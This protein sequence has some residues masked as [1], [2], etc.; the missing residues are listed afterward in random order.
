MSNHAHGLWGYTGTTARGRELTIQATGVGGPSAALVLADLAA[1]GV[2]RA[3]RV[4]TCVA[5]DDLAL[6]TIVN[7]DRALAFD[8][9]S[10]ALGA[11]PRPCPTRGLRQSC[12]ARPGGAPRHGRAAAT[13]RMTS[14]TTPTT[15]ARRRDW[16]D[17]GAIAA[18]MAAAPCSRPGRRL[19]VATAG[20]L[21]VTELAGADERIGDDELAERALERGAVLD[22]RRALVGPTRPDLRSA[23]R[24]TSAISSSRSSTSSRRPDRMRSRRSSRSTSDA[25]GMFIALIAERWAASA[26]SPAPNVVERTELKSGF[27]SSAWA[28]SPS[29]SSPA[30]E[31]RS[32]SSCRPDPSRPLRSLRSP[33]ASSPAVMAWG[34]RVPPVAA[35]WVK[36]GACVPI[37]FRVD[38][39]CRNANP[40]SRAFSSASVRQLLY[41]CAVGVGKRRFGV[42]QRGA[43]K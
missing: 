27:S 41:G 21:V 12:G 4:G 15:A 2:R 23:D 22:R 37:C 6:G 32:R 17:R 35:A 5:L 3:V 14:A 18:E 1:L 24:A 36:P 43:N 11:N 9:T 28:I 31:S 16:R 34:C 7:C 38:P 29:A 13:C 20:I 10:R 42:A 39:P 8:G 33:V 40:I 19:G 30:L 26:R 25:A